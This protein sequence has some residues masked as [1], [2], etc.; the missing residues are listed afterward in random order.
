M[1]C[2]TRVSGLLGKNLLR[3]RDAVLER[4]YRSVQLLLV[5]L[6]QDGA[7]ARPRR[8]PKREKVTSLDDWLWRRMLDPQ[9]LRALEEPVHRRAVEIPGSAEA[10]RFGH[11]GEE[12]EI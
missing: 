7:D 10:V 6:A 3:E 1:T 4:R 11:A 12:F 2:A 9:Q 8:Q 5:D